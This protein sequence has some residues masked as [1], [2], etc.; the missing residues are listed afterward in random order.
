MTE[1]YWLDFPAFPT[2]LSSDVLNKGIPLSYRVHIWHG[3]TRMAG[4]QSGESRT[5]INS[6]VWAQYINVTDTQPRRYMPRQRN[7]SGGKSKRKSNRRKQKVGP[8]T[9]CVRN[10]CRSSAVAA[11]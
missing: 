7:A 1:T 3:K 6:V 9:P 5:M 8:I 10:M 2:P 11:S 4:L